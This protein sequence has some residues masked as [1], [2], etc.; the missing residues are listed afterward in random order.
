MTHALEAIALGLSLGPACLG[1]CGP[2]LFPFLVSAGRPVAGTSRLFVEFLAGRLAGYLVFAAIAWR[3]GTSLPADVRIRTWLF[4]FAHAAIAIWMIVYALPLFR[5]LPSDCPPACAGRGRLVSRA[6]APAVLGLL[7]GL[8]LCPP[9]I[10]AGLRAAEASGLAAAE[11]FFVLFFVGT[12]AWLIPAVGTGLFRRV[13]AAATIA[14][15]MMLILGAWY[16]YVAAISLTRS[17]VHG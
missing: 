17:I 9:F 2:I 10:T 7:T 6:K 12:S 15:M 11:L 3:L 8:N 1:S 4:A 5:Q 13:P 16:G 14:R